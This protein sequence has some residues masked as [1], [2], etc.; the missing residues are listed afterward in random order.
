MGHSVSQDTAVPGPANVDLRVAR[1]V[2]DGRASA[3]RDAATD[4][5]EAQLRMTEGRA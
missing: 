1:R 5:L 4:R 2:V 3:C